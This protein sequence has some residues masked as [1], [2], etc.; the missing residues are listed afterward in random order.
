MLYGSLIDVIQ[1]QEYQ[2]N[3]GSPRPKELEEPKEP[4]EIKK[5]VEEVNEEKP[6]EAEEEIQNK[7]V[8]AKPL[9]LISTDAI[10]D[11]LVYVKVIWYAL[12]CCWFDFAIIYNFFGSIVV[13]FE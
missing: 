4:E 9:P 3:I 8:E 1:H 6:L 13:G 10:V 5:Q 2:K 7:E 12:L 11:L